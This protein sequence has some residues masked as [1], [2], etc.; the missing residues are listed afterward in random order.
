[1]DGFA[2]L[3]RFC[4]TAISAVHREPNCLYHNFMNVFVFVHTSNKKPR[5]D[6]VRE[7][8]MEWKKNR[9]DEAALKVLFGKRTSRMEEAKKGRGT[10]TSFFTRKDCT[11][12][13]NENASADSTTPELQS[14][15]VS[16][17]VQKST[18]PLGE[19]LKEARTSLIQESQERVMS[20]VFCDGY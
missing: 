8:Q 10:I 20:H 5:A 1:M 3:F 11:K 18:L 15:V 17:S 6:V 2:S 12:K 13:D 7:G 16:V 4:S 14:E 9:E 19:E